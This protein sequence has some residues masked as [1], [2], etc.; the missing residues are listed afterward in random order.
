ML[1]AG[2]T[3]IAIGVE[4]EAEPIGL[5]LARYSQFP[6]EGNKIYGQILSVFFVPA[7]RCQEIGT[8]LFTRM[9]RE[10]KNRGCA[11]IELHY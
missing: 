5:I 7:Y 6:E 10:L 2:A 1:T 9:E 11:E 8:E 4:L 3:V